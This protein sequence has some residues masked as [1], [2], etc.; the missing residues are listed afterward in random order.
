MSD[1]TTIASRSIADLQPVEAYDFA[2]SHFLF[3]QNEIGLFF[4]RVLP[5]STMPAHAHPD[6]YQFSFI[7]SGRGR[8]EAGDCSV[9]VHE[10]LCIRIPPGVA[11]SWQNT[12]DEPLEYVEAK[13]PAGPDADMVSYVK[14]LFP[15]VDN[16]RLGID[17]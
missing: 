6:C 5:H 10:G 7:V 16:H 12:G 14:G 4:T 17:V 9:D 15:D 2:D 13:V 1:E 8:L 11:H 3:V